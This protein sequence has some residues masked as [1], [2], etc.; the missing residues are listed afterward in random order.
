MA[1]T[2]HYVNMAGA[3][4]GAFGD[5]SVCSEPDAVEVPPPPAANHTWSGTDW[6]APAP[7]PSDVNAE[8][9][10]RIAAGFSFSGHLFQADSESLSNINGAVSGALAAKGAGVAGDATNWFNGT[11]LNWIAADN[12]PVAMTPDQVIAFGQAAMA[13]KARHIQVARGLKDMNP[14]PLDYTDDSHWT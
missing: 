12:T 5:G 14:I 7:T 9:D 2:K 10:R 4:I 13:H 1:N 6:V 8:R 3:Y 11:T